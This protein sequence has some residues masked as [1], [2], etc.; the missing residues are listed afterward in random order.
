MTGTGRQAEVQSDAV[1]LRHGL[2]QLA[3]ECTGSQEQQLLAYLDL[4]E[5][6]NQRFNL[7]AIRDRSQMITRHL[8]DSL[9]VLP[10]LRGTSFMDVG[11]G[12]GLPGIP[13]A[14]AQPER[15]F[16]L[17]DSNGKKTRF[18]TQAIAT[19]GLRNASAVHARVES[20][21]PVALADAVLSRAFASLGDMIAGCRHLL[22]PSGEFLALKGQ[23][24][25]D[26]LAEL[27]AGD[28]GVDV[29][30][31]IPLS[32]PGL[33]EERCLVRLLRSR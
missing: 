3:L 10:H 9:A 13:L 28:S 20:H 33:H 29:L 14:I 6:W 32:I 25:H 23:H 12:A 5:R 15:Q 1:A 27:E 17:L 18:M 30:E 16:T 24:P 26:E 21:T 31:V 22:K 11:S 19:L 4:L 8:L 7:T 2:D